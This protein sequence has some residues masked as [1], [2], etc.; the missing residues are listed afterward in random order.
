VTELQTSGASSVLSSWESE[1][2]ESGRMCAA[3]SF[4]YM[5]N[6]FF[7]WLLKKV[8]SLIVFFVVGHVS[9]VTLYL[10]QFCSK[11]EK[12]ILAY[13]LGEISGSQAD[14]YEGDYLLGCCTV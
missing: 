11:I 3:V 5:M 7:H 9:H 12:E 6:L 2:S 1:L 14:E 8:S 4:E 13:L 10:S